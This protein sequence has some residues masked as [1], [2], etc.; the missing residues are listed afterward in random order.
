[1]CSD[2]KDGLVD[3]KE[4]V[5]PPMMFLQVKTENE[6]SVASDCYFLSSS[7]KC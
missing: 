4:E 1:M 6:V 3:V 5:V 7:V 2:N